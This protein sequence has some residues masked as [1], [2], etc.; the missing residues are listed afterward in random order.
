MKKTPKKVQVK[1]GQPGCGLGL[2]AAEAVKKEAFIIE[3]VGKKIPT[4]I[5]DTLSTKYL[6]DLE[7]GWT[8]DGSTRTNTARYINHGCEPNVEA[9]LDEDQGRIFIYATRDIKP[10]EEFLIDYGDEYVDEFIKPYGC[11]CVSCVK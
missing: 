5:A 6:F 9:E 3:Y 4:V 8:I 10:G 7:N 11:K 2:F 1:R